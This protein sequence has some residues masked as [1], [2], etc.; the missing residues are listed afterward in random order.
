M[1][2]S[3]DPSFNN[4]IANFPKRPLRI[5]KTGT[6]N[7]LVLCLFLVC[8]AFTFGLSYGY[9]S[10][11]NKYEI[12]KAPVEAQNV[13]Y[14][15]R[16]CRG[17]ANKNVSCSADVTYSDAKGR[18]YKKTIRANTTN[19]TPDVRY[20]D[21]TVVYAAGN[22]DNAVFK[23]ALQG[24][25]YGSV[26]I[27]IFFLV[28]AFGSVALFLE[29][30]RNILSNRAIKNK[31]VLLHPLVVEVKRYFPDISGRPCFFFLSNHG[32]K[33]ECVTRFGRDEE[34]FFVVEAGKKTFALAVQAHHMK[35]PVLLDEALLRISLSDAEKQS[36]YHARD[37]IQQN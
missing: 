37:A 17:N 21:F 12:W 2:P 10:L 19:Y 18:V 28:M 9:P 11:K 15:N 23:M 8:C 36:L 24:F 4:I 3:T 31:D 7:L 33:K 30:I 16:Q 32:K 27:A 1:K 29:L 6:R 25:S 14:K 13:Q 26:L 22:P 35:K 5:L 20:Q 34:P